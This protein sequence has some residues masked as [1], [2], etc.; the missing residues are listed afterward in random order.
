MSSPKPEK[1]NLD[2]LADEVLYDGFF[3]LRRVTLSHQLFAGGMSPPIQREVLDM[4]RAVAVLL[5]DPERDALV[6]IEQFRIGAINPPAGGWVL[7]LVAGIVEPG[8]SDTELAH[9]ESMEEAGC[10][11]SDLALINEYMVAP[12]AT[13]ERIALYVARVDARTA[14]GIH[15]L[16]EE[17]ED[18]RVRVLSAEQAIAET[19]PGGRINTTTPIIAMQWFAANRDALRTRWLASA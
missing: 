4:R 16:R 1:R 7:E 12:A 13:T 18:I 6:M 5:Y 19:R 11:I 8:E 17:G 3:R 15:G 14:H 2:I 9:R 10:T